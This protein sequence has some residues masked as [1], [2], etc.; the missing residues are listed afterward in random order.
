MTRFLMSVEESVN[1]VLYAFENSEPGDIFVQKSPASTIGDLAEAI[2][3]L[4]KPNHPI[5]II[6]TRHGEK[7]YE[8]LVSQEEMLRAE[9]RGKFYRI[10]SDSRDLNYSKYFSDGSRELVKFSDYSSHNTKRLT[11]NE[12]KETLL[13]L[14]IIQDLVK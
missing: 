7:P 11:V 6:G 2:R 8:T 12:I 9:D 3:Q 14:K 5:N 13:K 10:A 1:L 4:L